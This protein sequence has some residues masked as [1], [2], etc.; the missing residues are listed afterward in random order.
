MENRNFVGSYGLFATIVVSLIG[1]SGFAYPRELAIIIGTDGW[2]VTIFAGLIVF[3]LLNLVYKLIKLNNF[4]TFNNILEN[5]LGKVI[6]KIVAVIFVVYNL[7]FVA[8]SM[9]SFV[10]VLKMYLLPKTP[11][12][13]ILIVMILTGTYLIRGDIKSLVK[14]NEVIFW[15]MFIPIILVMFFTLGETDFT[16][17]LPIL[18]NEPLNYIGAT[19]KALFAFIGFQSIYL[20]LPYIKNRN[21]ISKILF[22]S[23]LFAVLFYVL[24]FTFVLAVFSIEQTKVLLWP[25]I[26]MIKSVCISSFFVER[27]EGV[28]MAFWIL[29]YFTTFTN[30]YYLSAD[31]GKSIFKLEDVKLSSLIMAPAIYVIALYPENIAE[32]YNFEMKIIP[33]SSLA[34]LVILPIIL[35]LISIL[36]KKGGRKGE[37]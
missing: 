13:F 10:E 11:T 5:N 2:I 12:E 29:F 24:I 28:A 37:I 1:I 19:G 8:I 21:N 35:Y 20:V 36:K 34:M 6:G 3:F 26:T 16:N 30:I 25:T 14:F 4:G 15:L 17:L 22:K 7:I 33:I 31:V 23:M 27:W 32:V 18:H 9:R